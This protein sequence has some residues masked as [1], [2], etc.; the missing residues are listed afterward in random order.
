MPCYYNFIKRSQF[1]SCSSVIIQFGWGHTGTPPTSTATIL[2]YIHIYNVATINESRVNLLVRLLTSHQV[3]ESDT[4]SSVE[5]K[6]ET[7]LYVVYFVPVCGIQWM[8]RIL[9]IK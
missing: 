2:C 3:K 6:Y 4:L 7:P 9:F 8:P 5:S 1:E